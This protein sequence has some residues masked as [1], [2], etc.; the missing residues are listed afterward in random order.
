[1]N[2]QQKISL[3]KGGAE[4]ISTEYIV[5]LYKKYAQDLKKVRSQQY[6]FLIRNFNSLNRRLYRMGIRTHML[7][8]MLDDIEAEV[9]Y[10]LIRENHPLLTVEMSPNTG[11]ST[12]WILSALRDNG[13]QGQLWS[14]DLHDTSTKYVPKALAEGR[15]NFVLGDARKNLCD[16]SQIDYF[17]IDS[18]HTK[19]FAFW[20]VEKIL[21]SLRSTCKVS[22]HDVFHES[23]PSEEG[24]IVI[25]WLSQH[26]KT[27]WSPSPFCSKWVYQ[28]LLEERKCL[29]MKH[30]IH[31]RGKDNPMIFFDL[32]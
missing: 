1:M 6:W 13:G 31:K 5:S 20:Y 14:Y 2:S 29:G 22:V 11:W 27:F 10:L 15:W 12:T 7:H 24:R 23:S 3:V 28:T 32:A 30:P 25:S 8:P 26:G 19:E 21:P 16:F 9:T 4:M 17:F 18:D